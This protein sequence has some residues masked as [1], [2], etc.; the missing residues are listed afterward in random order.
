MSGAPEHQKARER[1]ETA[2]F[3]VGS[4]A[5]FLGLSEEQQKLVQLRLAVSR[6]IRARREAQGLTQ[7]QLAGR[8]N[9]SQSR[10]AKLEKGE[11]GVSLDLSFRALFALGADVQDLW[12]DAMIAGSKRPRR[13][14][15]ARSA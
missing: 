11:P 1:L 7:A 5:E 13:G 14:S 12:A 8:I 10:V 9:S 6:L 3:R 4:A 15:K 2:G